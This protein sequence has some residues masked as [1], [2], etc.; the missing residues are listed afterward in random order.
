MAF[1]HNKKRDAGILI[2][3]WRCHVGDNARIA[4]EKTA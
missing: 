4:A 3:F 2:S 1:G